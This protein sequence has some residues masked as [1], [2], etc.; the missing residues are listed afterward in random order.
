MKNTLYTVQRITKKDIFKGY[1]HGSVD[2]EKSVCGIEF[3]NNWY[4]LNNTFDGKITCKKCI[5]EMENK[6][7]NEL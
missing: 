4:I 3:D 1:I 5:K 2:G 6:L 7:Y